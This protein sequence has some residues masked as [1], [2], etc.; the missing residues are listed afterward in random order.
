MIRIISNM[1]PVYWLE[2]MDVDAAKI[3]SAALVNW[4]VYYRCPP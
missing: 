3:L 1:V 2:D 4:H